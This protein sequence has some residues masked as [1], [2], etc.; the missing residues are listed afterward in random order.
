MRRPIFYAVGAIAAGCVL[1]AMGIGLVGCSKRL[2]NDD[3]APIIVRNGSMHI[4]TTD[5]RWT[6]EG[7]DWSNETPPDKV[8]DNDL[9]VAV[10]STT[11][12]KCPAALTHGHPVIVR[13]S[14]P[15]VQAHFNPGGNPTRT[16][17]KLTGQ[18]RRDGDHHL[19]H[20]TA[21]DGGSIAEIRIGQP[22]QCDLSK[23]NL[24]E[25]RI[26]SSVTRR[27]CQ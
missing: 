7:G 26:C 4:E 1:G 9:W 12:Q 24:R 10:I 3:E 14:D 20:G 6:P 2:S 25:I 22:L 15:G 19:S 17:V 23:G 8:H 16:K 5:G 11:G 27:E 21:G 13:Y 18:W